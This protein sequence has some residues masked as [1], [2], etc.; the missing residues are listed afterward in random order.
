MRPAA[1]L[2]VP[3]LMS[4]VRLPL[5]AAIWIEPGRPLALLLLMLLAGGSDLLD[6]AL[7]RRYERRG[8]LRDPE[9]IGTWLDPLCD[10]AFILS[11]AGA[12]WWTHRVPVAYLG[13]LALRELLQ[14]PFVLVYLAQPA[15]RHRL[16]YDFRASPAGKL[17]T[18]LQ[19]AA[20]TAWLA[21]R[22]EPAR[23]LSLAAALAGVI[24]ALLYLRRAQQQFQHRTV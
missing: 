7:A 2:D 22:T 16:H 18:A 21:A 12:L 17:T 3:N 19:L 1:L 14:L 15:L 9:H 4:L 13:L 23:W 5:A 20:V 11:L 10:K 24:A 8:E 6:G